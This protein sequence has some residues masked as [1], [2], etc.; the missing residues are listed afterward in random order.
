[1][2]EPS[3]QAPGALNWALILGLGV[4]WGTAFMGVEVSL[5]EFSP[6][7]VAAARTALGALILAVVGPVLGQGLS[8]LPSRRAWIFAILLGVF[9]AAVPFSL[10]SW[11]Q[12]H[13]PSAFAGV[14]MGAVPLLTLLLVMQ[15]SPD[16]GVGPRRILG[17]ALGFVGL[18]ILVGPGAFGAGSDLVALG[19]LACAASAACYAVANVLTRRAPQMPPVA[20]ATV[21]LLTA[22]TLLT[23]LALIVEG[24]P[25]VQMDAALAA[26][27]WVA[28]GPT[29]MAAL[30]QVRVI[31]SAGSLFLSQVSYMVPVWSVIFGIA[32]L[33]E[34]LPRELFIA[35]ALILAGIGLSQWSARRRAPPDS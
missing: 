11:G 26:L 24:V 21:A 7:T 35:L 20:M 16:E 4:V 12:Q 31:Q 17:V 29:A 8:T 6:L 23:P 5:R 3:P 32:I 27:I 9:A 28:L 34:T 10:L 14:T 18:V 33:G 13:V 22:A 15:F 19:R 30:V 1:M 25:T 2:T